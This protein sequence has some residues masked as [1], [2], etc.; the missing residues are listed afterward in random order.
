MT[1]SNL[2]PAWAGLSSLVLIVNNSLSYSG[3]EMNASPRGIAKGAG[4]RVPKG[5]L[6]RYGT[7]AAALRPSGSDC[8]CRSSSTGS[9][10]HRGSSRSRRR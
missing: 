8:S 2:L 10:S 4:Q 6:P 1:A 3:M 7:G 9:A 5:D